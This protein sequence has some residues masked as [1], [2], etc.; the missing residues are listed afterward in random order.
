MRWKGIIGFEGQMTGDGRFLE[1]NS[2][3]WDNLPIPL[4]WAPSDEGAHKGAVQVGNIDKV[5]R[6]ANGAIYGEGFLDS[7]GATGK[8]AIR[9]MESGFLRGV[10]MDLD[11]SSF[12]LRVRA[13]MFAEKPETLPVDDD[14]MVT[15]AVSTPTDEVT[16]FTD[17]QLRGATLVDIPAFKDALVSLEEQDEKALAASV[18]DYLVY[19]DRKDRSLTAGAF[20]VEPPSA[21][22]VDPGLKEPTPLTIDDDGRIYGHLAAWGTCHAA[23]PGTCV[24]PPSSRS[25]Y[26]HFRL[27]AVKT[28]DGHTVPVGHITMSTLHADRNADVSS[29]IYHYEHTGRVAADVA[30]GEDSFGIWVA[31]AVRPGITKN[32]LRE[33]RAS[34]LSGD[35]R[36]VAGNLELVAALAVNVPGFP[37]PRPQGFV[38]SGEQQS[39]IASGVL[40]KDIKERLA[41]EKILQMRADLLAEGLGLS[42]GDE[43]PDQMERLRS[44]RAGLLRDE[45]EQFYAPG[46]PRDARGRWAKSGG[47]GGTDTGGSGGSYP[48]DVVARTSRQFSED[49]L[50]DLATPTRDRQSSGSGILQ[51]ENGRLNPERQ[52]HW[53]KAI[54]AGLG[55]VTPE[56]V[57]VMTFTG[58]GPASGKSELLA[59]SPELTTNRVIP[60]PD[61]F[62]TGM[63]GIPALPEHGT[64]I[65]TP[66]FLHEES[67]LMAK[68]LTKIAMERGLS[69]TVDGVGDAGFK[70][71]AGKIEAAEKAGY[72]VDLQYMTIPTSEAL[73]RAKRRGMGSGPDARVLMSTQVLHDHSDVSATFSELVSSGVAKNAVL[74]NNDVQRGTPPTK[75]LEIVNGKVTVHDEDRWD[76]FRSKAKDGSNPKAAFQ[77][78]ADRARSM[79]QR[80]TSPEDQQLLFRVAEEL[81]ADADAI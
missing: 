68:D 36:R 12:E 7:E 22:F 15:V 13:E 33:L 28:S 11:E 44:F 63:N 14:G 65:G 59:I 77:A 35:W 81:Q 16:V 56:P 23:Y 21:W 8:E 60:N 79:S 20:P 9:L 53:N 70:K 66:S 74:W 39:L 10:S 31:G 55:N 46:Q 48:D 76:D 72:K 29:T 58:G 75:I 64:P 41:Q 40:A 32:Q 47:F 52:E 50:K 30:V 2:L 24:T 51:V 78:A 67:S 4:R 73:I 45:V 6:L 61:D 19:M 37:I 57:K 54:T 42:V 43:Q 26:S 49:E 27:G 62:K 38:A 3:R 1:H 71:M 80:S 5:K 25:A 34:P 18:A 17:T 69:V